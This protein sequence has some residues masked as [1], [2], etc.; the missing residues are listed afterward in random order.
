[1]SKEATMRSAKE[2]RGVRIRTHRKHRVGKLAEAVF[3]PGEKRV[4]GYMVARPDFLW[5]FKR[6]DRFVAFD[7]VRT[8]D[9]KLYA[10]PGGDVWDKGALTR[11]G[12]DLDE[13]IVWRNMPVTTEAGREV[14]RVCDLA[15]DE[16]NGRLLGV[17]L[18]DG[19]T[20]TLLVG[21]KDIPASKIVSCSVAGVVIDDS[22]LAV[23][24]S[25]GIAGAAGK[26]AAVATKRVSETATA[27]LE[28]AGKATAAVR[29]RTGGMFSSFKDEFKS[30]MTD[31][32]KD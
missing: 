6:R 22:A 13:C 12:V 20:A 18:S 24:A 21:R 4:V 26:S 11:L 8:E 9:G 28:A 25:G 32:D 7:K 31:E 19:A 23:E 30:G 16:R 3:A 17:R 29:K 10:L 27:T 1:M 5:M 15:F 14:G 2:M